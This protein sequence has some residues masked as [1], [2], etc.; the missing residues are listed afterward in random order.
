MIWSFFEIL[1]HFH[2]Q[3]FELCSPL[4]PEQINPSVRHRESKREGGGKRHLG[5]SAGLKRILSLKVK[6]LKGQSAP[7]K[8]TINGIENLSSR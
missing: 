8:K 7:L 6:G 1:T 4:W 2:F 5:P 3:R